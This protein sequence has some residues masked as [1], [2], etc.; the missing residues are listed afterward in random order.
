MI[1]QAIYPVKHLWCLCQRSS[2]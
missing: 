2:S 1:S